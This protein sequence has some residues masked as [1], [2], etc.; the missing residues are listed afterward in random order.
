MKRAKLTVKP[1]AQFRKDYKAALKSGRN[2]KLLE[3]VITKLAMDKTLPNKNKDHPLTGNWAG[4][5]E[6][7][8]TPDWFLIYRINSSI[9]VLTLSRTGSHSK[10]L[11][12]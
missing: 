3:E 2:I 11:N 4:H 9:L 7:Y 10:L 12:K 1:T 8:I 6:C 5:R